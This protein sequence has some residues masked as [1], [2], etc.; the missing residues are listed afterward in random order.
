MLAS[1]HTSLY[2][3]M[4]AVDVPHLRQDTFQIK[5]AYAPA[6]FFESRTEFFSKQGVFHL[7]H[8]IGSVDQSFHFHVVVLVRST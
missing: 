5:D 3:S 7:R 8:G 2:T 4:S 6:T 1:L